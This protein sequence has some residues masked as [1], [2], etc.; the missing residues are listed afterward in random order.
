MDLE[1]AVANA[2][3]Y[4]GASVGKSCGVYL[5]DRDHPRC[6]FKLGYTNRYSMV[7]AWGAHCIKVEKFDLRSDKVRSVTEDLMKPYDPKVESQYW[8]GLA[9]GRSNRAKE[10]RP[11]LKEVKKKRNSRSA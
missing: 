1:L 9:Q 11:I 7:G 2:G 8:Q 6:P 3:K 10:K 4:A 5:T